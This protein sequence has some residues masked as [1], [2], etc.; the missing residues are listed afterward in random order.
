MFKKAVY[1]VLFCLS[2]C[3][4][5]AE[6]VNLLDR[7]WVLTKLEQ[8]EIDLQQYETEKPYIELQASNRYSAYA[9]CNRI[10]GSFTL[11][12]PNTLVFLPNAIMTKMACMQPSNIEDLFLK[13][14]DQVKTW[15]IKEQRLI[16]S[17]IN[18][19]ILAVFK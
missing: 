1:I 11:S 12:E 18:G 4:I 3:L 7:K 8:T 9:G 5:A 16:L 13:V 2:P 19:N 10:S 14:L 17:N 6:T 15:E